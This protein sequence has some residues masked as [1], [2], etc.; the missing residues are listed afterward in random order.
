MKM[1]FYR[2]NI[3]GSVAEHSP[4]ENKLRPNNFRIGIGIAIGIGFEFPVIQNKNR[5]P[6]AIAISI[7]IL[8]AIAIPIAACSSWLMGLAWIG[9]IGI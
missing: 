4:T 5:D 2:V 3:A 1:F 9:W 6:I 8:M 7:P